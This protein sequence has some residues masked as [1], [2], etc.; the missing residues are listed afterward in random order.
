MCRPFVIPISAII[1]ETQK[2]CPALANTH[3]IRTWA[4]LI[5][6]TF[7]SKPILGNVPD[8]S[9]LYIAAGHPHAMSHAPAVGEVFTEL[10]MNEDSMSES[11]K[12]IFE[13]AC[14]TRFN[15]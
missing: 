2:I 1:K 12:F 15:R 3:I 11:A 10:I 13:Q 8:V 4:A 7:D 6:Y 5:P 14:L 9:G